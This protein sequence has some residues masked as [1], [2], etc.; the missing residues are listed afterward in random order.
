MLE[1]S[2]ARP[3]IAEVALLA[4]QHRQDPTLQRVEEALR[5]LPAGSEPAQKSTATAL[6]ATVLTYLGDVQQATQGL[7]RP[8]KR[9]RWTAIMDRARQSFAEHLEQDLGLALSD[10]R[11]ATATLEKI[12]DPLLEV[13]KRLVAPQGVRETLKAAPRALQLGEHR[14]GLRREL[15]RMKVDPG[16]EQ[17]LGGVDPARL[18]T[19]LR[20]D[21]AWQ[22]LFQAVLRDLESALR[23]SRRGR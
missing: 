12:A 22:A 4:R 1:I 21:P 14:K 3:A 17:E 19:S 7:T 18:I 10:A 11:A 2:E 8:M 23:S 9:E 5:Q 15:Q 6:R 16:L 20:T 13:M